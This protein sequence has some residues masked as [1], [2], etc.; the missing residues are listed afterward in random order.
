MQRLNIGSGTDYREGWINLDYNPKYKP[1]VVWDLTKLP[2]PFEDSTF[3]EIIMIHVLEHF[4]DPLL[5][6]N[7]MWRIGKAGCKITIKV[8]HWSCH[9]SA[10]DLT[11]HHRFSSREF[12]H[13][14]LDKVY[15]NKEIDFKV[16]A[17]LNCINAR[18][19]LFARMIN[20]VMN[21]LLNWNFSITEN[22]L[23]KVFPIYENIYKLEVV[24]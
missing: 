19:R 9:F 4:H 14:N 1:E 18:G 7:E 21:P 12:S 5:L 8:P 17:R 23:C 10:G 3:D 6:V 22:F 13:F 2:L 20:A 15:Y 24:K 16:T 11:H